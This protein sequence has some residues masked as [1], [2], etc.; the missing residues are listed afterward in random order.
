MVFWL[1]TKAS[2][3]QMVETQVIF[4]Y[5]VWT[6]FEKCYHMHPYAGH[7]T[8]CAVDRYKACLVLPPFFVQR[9][10]KVTLIK[11]LPQEIFSCFSR[12][13]ELLEHSEMN[14]LPLFY[15]RDTGSP[16]YLHACS[17]FSPPSVLCSLFSTQP[18]LLGTDLLLVTSSMEYTLRAPL[19]TF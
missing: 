3:P 6:N 4:Q 7:W 5:L 13:S 19:S 16:P 9:W 18:I 2:L 1:L 15:L 11:T 10:E 14:A 12:H 17:P 8:V